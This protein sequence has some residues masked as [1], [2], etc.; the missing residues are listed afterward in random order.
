MHVIKSLKWE[1][2]QMG[3]VKIVVPEVVFLNGLKVNKM[4][5][6][7]LIPQIQVRIDRMN[8]AI[9]GFYLGCGF[10]LM[11]YFL[12]HLYFQT[13]FTLALL[14]V[15]AIIY[16]FSLILRTADLLSYYLAKP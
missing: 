8:K 13:P 15:S 10:A 7:A 1:L 3:V 16:G 11:G 2:A 6:E 9:T 12:A 14:K 4:K 5:G